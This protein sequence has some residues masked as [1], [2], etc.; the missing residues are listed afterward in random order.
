M[1]QVLHEFEKKQKTYTSHTQQFLYGQILNMAEIGRHLLYGEWRGMPCPKG[2]E[3][4]ENRP[5]IWCR[6]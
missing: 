1:S 4:K 6:V 2:W 5:F 3:Q